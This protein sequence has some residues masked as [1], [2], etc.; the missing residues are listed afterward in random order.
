M[1]D[2]KPGFG[3]PL[4]YHLMQQGVLDLGPGVPRDVTPADGNA[5][6]AAGPDLH[7]E[8]AQPGAHAAREPDR[9]LA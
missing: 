8:L 6:G 1:I 9:D 4:V 2:L 3:L 7:R 5:E